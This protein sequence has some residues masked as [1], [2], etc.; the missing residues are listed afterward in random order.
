MEQGSMGAP[1]KEG[2]SEVRAAVRKQQVGA[3]KALTH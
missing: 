3:Q 2:N 1:V